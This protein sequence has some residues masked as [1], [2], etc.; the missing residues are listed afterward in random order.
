MNKSESAN[1]SSGVAQSAP[2]VQA[3]NGTASAAATTSPTPAVASNVT[4]QLTSAEFIELEAG[5][6]DLLCHLEHLLSNIREAE[7]ADKH[8]VLVEVSQKMLSVMLDFVEAFL[9]GSSLAKSSE[10]IATAF[11][12]SQVLKELTHNVSIGGLLR[13]TFG[14]TDP[15]QVVID[16]TYNDLCRALKRAVVT[17]LFHAIQAVG[18]ETPIGQQIDQSTL[19]FVSE[20]ESIKIS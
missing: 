2:M 10:E 14:G 12:N 16:E 9:S 8:E 3:Q 5:V 6:V 17:L 4:S 7:P 1:S 13:R 20:L 19:L 18:L 11:T 15:N